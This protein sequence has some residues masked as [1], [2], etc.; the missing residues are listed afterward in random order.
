[1]A[2]N[3][4]FCL[5]GAMDLLWFHQIILFPESLSLYFPITLKPLHPY[6]ESTTTSPS[7]SLSSLAEDISTAVCP[8]PDEENL[9]SSSPL[10]PLGDS[11]NEEEVKSRPKRVSLSSSR[12][13]SHSSSPSSQK[14]QRNHGHSTSCSLGGKLQKPMSCRSLKDL[15]LEE[16][17]GFMGLGFIFKKEH[18]NARMISVVPGLLRLGFFRTKQKTDE[19]NLAANE[20]PKD[21]DI[22]QEEERC[23]IRPYL[24]EAWLIKRPDSPLVNLR[25]PRVSATADMK[26]HLKFWARTVASVVQ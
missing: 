7:S 8:L 21:D 18:L 17:K 15:E 5:I 1:M 19:L 4:S 6:S 22:E 14:R 2:D 25:V 13:R 3:F 16:V 10:T 12:S 9:S 23:V 26:K 11:K 24:S 20:L